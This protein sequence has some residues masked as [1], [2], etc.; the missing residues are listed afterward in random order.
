MAILMIVQSTRIPAPIQ[1]TARGVNVSKFW[2]RYHNRISNRVR[3][4]IRHL[5]GLKVRSEY[6]TGLD[7]RY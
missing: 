2:I 7:I 5:T 1:N 6:L 3:Y 4:A